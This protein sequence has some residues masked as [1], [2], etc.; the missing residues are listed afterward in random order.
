MKPWVADYFEEPWLSDGYSDDLEDV[1]VRT[2]AVFYA[3][4]SATALRMATAMQED[5]EHVVRVRP[6]SGE[7]RLIGERLSQ[8]ESRPAGDNC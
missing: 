8:T 4:D 7:P 1:P 5:G 3:V 2:S 6:D